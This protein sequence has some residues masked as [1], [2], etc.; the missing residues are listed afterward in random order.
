MSMHACVKELAAYTGCPMS[1]CNAA[2]LYARDHDDCT[3]IGFLKAKCNAVATPKMTFEERVRMFSR[4][5]MRDAT[6]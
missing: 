5:E 3:P 1:L 2:F 6:D 4:G